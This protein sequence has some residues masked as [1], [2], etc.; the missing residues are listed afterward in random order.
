MANDLTFRIKATDNFSEIIEKM[1]KSLNSTSEEAKKLDS[2]TERLNEIGNSTMRSMQMGRRFQ[3]MLKQLKGNIPDEQ[4]AQLKQRMAEVT[5]Q[6][7]RA[8][9]GYKNLTNLYASRTQYIDAAATAFQGLSSIA[10][11]TT[12]SL[13][14]FGDENSESTKK[15]QDLVNQCLTLTVGA[16]GLSSAVKGLKSAQLAL[17]RAFS[18]NPWGVAIGGAVALGSVIYGLYKKF[19]DTNKEADK[20][21]KLLN[22]INQSYLDNAQNV[23]QYHDNLGK[24][25]GKYTE[26]QAKY[27]SL[28]TEL[29][30]TQFIKENQSAFSQLG[31]SVKSLADAENIFVKNTNKVVRAMTLRAQAT[32]L[33]KRITDAYTAYFT[34]E[35]KI[36]KSTQK[37]KKGNQIAS[38]TAKQM[39][40]IE[41]THYTATN[42]PNAVQLTAQGAR[43]YNYQATHDNKAH[44][45]NVSNL[46]KTVGSATNAISKIS[47]DL[48]KLNVLSSSTSTTT[49]ATGNGKAT[50]NGIA[51]QG[52]KAQ[53]GSVTQIEN[54][55]KAT[56]EEQQALNA[57]SKRFAELGKKIAQL[58]EQLKKANQLQSLSLRDA[59]NYNPTTIQPRANQPLR[60]NSPLPT[61]AK[62][63]GVTTP[64]EQATQLDKI[65]NKWKEIQSLAEKGFMPQSTARQQQQALQSLA[66]QMGISAYTF[67]ALTGQKG[68]LGEM[69]EMFGKINDGV[70]DFASGLGAVGANKAGKFITTISE[71]LAK[72]AE[73]IQGVVN[74]INLLTATQTTAT[75]VSVANSQKEASA[76]VANTGAKMGEAVAG[77]TASGAKLP[78]PANLAAIAAGVAAV[79]SVVGSIL[80][81]AGA[82]ADGG[83][84][85]GSSLHGDNLVARVNSG[86]MVLNGSQQRKLFRL[87][88]GN[89]NLSGN[90]NGT[91][92]VRIKGSDLVGAINN[93]NKKLNKIR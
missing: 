91:L 17:N 77:A 70:K 84:V 89:G 37:A 14:I 23:K 20:S 87:L 82:F 51:T 83:V 79:L 90:A 54:L 59:N 6:A 15:V 49:P 76:S 68:K 35:D 18:A 41:G 69:S 67:R 47:S 93:Y 1:K 19:G 7:Q 24:T 60:A 52:T 53:N 63:T 88:N 71:N 34:N 58:E 10:S 65:V 45:A 39:G 72:L 22:E 36:Y 75:A 33:E 57:N 28:T 25:I 27:K 32:A 5:A 3:T 9:K 64:Q 44:E 38:W 56:K 40:M 11:V 50:G 30:K 48:N 29:Q 46:N 78:F 62:L 85:G 21:T 61:T 73:N 80:S 4:L 13:A 66:K 8:E 92:T 31:L 55:L 74:L 81:V 42:N 16:Q 12:A 2:V 43:S 86:E 26:L